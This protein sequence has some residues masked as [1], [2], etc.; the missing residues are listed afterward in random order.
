VPGGGVRGNG[1]RDIRF[2]DFLISQP[3]G[4]TMKIKVLSAIRLLEQTMCFEVLHARH[5]GYTLPA[6]FGHQAFTYRSTLK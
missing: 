5:E 4:K 1:K 6:I 3:L 2:E